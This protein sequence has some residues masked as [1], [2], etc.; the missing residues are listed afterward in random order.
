VGRGSFGR[1]LC[2]RNMESLDP[3]FNIDP[4]HDLESLD[5]YMVGGFHPVQIGEELDVER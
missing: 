3:R 1:R 4:D 5:R 2:P